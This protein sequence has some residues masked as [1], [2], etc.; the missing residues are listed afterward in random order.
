MSMTLPILARHPGYVAERSDGIHQLS[1][2]S[3][4]DS[5]KAANSFCDLIVELSKNNIEDNPSR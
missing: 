1:H 5:D 2:I 3:P 4:P